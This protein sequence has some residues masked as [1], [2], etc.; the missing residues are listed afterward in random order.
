MKIC[1]I[2]FFCIFV[3]LACEHGHSKHGHGHSKHGQGGD[4]YPISQ[5][6]KIGKSLVAQRY[7]D[8]YFFRTALGF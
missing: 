7:S 8:I 1:R 2:L 3:M 6:L 5:D 4:Q